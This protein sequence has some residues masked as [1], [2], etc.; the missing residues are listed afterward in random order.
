M[1]PPTGGTSISA[2]SAQKGDTI[3]PGTLRSYQVYSRDANG[4]F[5]PTPTGDGWNV[6]NAQRVIW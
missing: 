4:A 2:A 1:F 3:V 6:S 5:C